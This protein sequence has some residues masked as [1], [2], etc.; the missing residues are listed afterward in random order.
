MAFSRA[1][2][3]VKNTAISTGIGTGFGAVSGALSSVIGTGL[4]LSVSKKPHEYD[5]GD[6]VAMTT[7]GSTAIFAAAG[8]L[9]KTPLSPRKAFEKIVSFDSACGLFIPMF[10]AGSEALAGYIGNEML[11]TILN[12][13]PLEDAFVQPLI[14]SPFAM[15]LIG[16]ACCIAYNCQCNNSSDSLESADLQ[17]I[18]ISSVPVNQG[19]RM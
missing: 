8:L 16:A 19:P 5:L 14:G 4:V 3:W 7:A 10:F 13:M 12:E 18:A 15:M 17:D 1:L 6:A 2:N 9:D 11:K